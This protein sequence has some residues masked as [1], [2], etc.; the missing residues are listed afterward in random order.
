MTNFVSSSPTNAIKE[1]STNLMLAVKRKEVEIIKNIMT[2]MI[3]IKL[4]K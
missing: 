1:I 2:G 4:F 3:R